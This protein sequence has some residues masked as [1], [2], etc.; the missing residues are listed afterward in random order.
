[1]RWRGRQAITTGV[2]GQPSPIG[3]GDRIEADLGA[4]GRVSVTINGA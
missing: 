4:L 2:T 3:D 1:V